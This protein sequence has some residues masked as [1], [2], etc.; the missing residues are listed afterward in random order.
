MSPETAAA[1]EGV[2]VAKG[3]AKVQRILG[4]VVNV[5]ADVPKDAVIL[6][7]A[8]SIAAPNATPQVDEPGRGHGPM[9]PEC[10]MPLITIGRNRL[11]NC[12]HMRKSGGKFVPSSWAKP[13]PKVEQPASGG[14]ITMEQREQISARIASILALQY[15]QLKTASEL[16]RVELAMELENKE[17][18][19]YFDSLVASPVV[20]RG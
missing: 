14:G 19:A 4:M 13:K 1:L 3:A 10:H 8:P 12:G 15:R 17:H 20:S 7:G 2:D 9:C 18:S 5:S 16:Q 6:A 11:S